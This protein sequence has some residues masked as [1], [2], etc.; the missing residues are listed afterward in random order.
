[1]KTKD[2]ANCAPLGDA[3]RVGDV[4][5]IGMAGRFPHAE[6]LETLRR[7]LAGAVDSVGP[8]SSTRI[9][10]TALP[11][12][13][14]YLLA[15]Y[16]D[17]V[18]KFDHQL[19]A[20]PLGE[21]EAMG[22][23]LRI[24]LEVVYGALENSG[25]GVDF[26][27]GS[28]AG[29]YAAQTSSAYY[30]HADELFSTLITGN[31]PDFFAARIARQF[32]LSGP[33]L[34]VDTAC[35]SG[36]VALHLA[37]QALAHGDVGHAVVC[38][39]HVHVFPFKSDT[40]NLLDV[41]A[42]DGK[43]RAF[44]ARAQGMSA[45]EVVCAL[46]L[47]PLAQAIHD[48][49][50]IH[51][52]VTGSAV[53]NNAARSSSPSAPDSAMQARVMQ[54][55]WRR[56][57]IAPTSLGFIE[58]H[59]SGTQLGD[60]LEVEAFTR[61]FRAYTDKTG[62][63]PIS[64][65]KSNIGHTHAAAGLAGLIKAVLSLKHRVVFPAVH[66][67][68]P[69][70]LIDF[71]RSAVYVNR[72]LAELQ[73][74][75]G[76]P[77]R[78]GVHA[79]G[80]SG[81]N[82]HVVMEEGPTRVM[83]HNNSPPPSLFTLSSRTG[84]GLLSAVRRLRGALRTQQLWGPDVAYTLNLGR[85]HFGRR[86][87]FVCSDIASLDEALARAAE[88][89]TVDD[90]VTPQPQKLIFA[91]SPCAEPSSTL[92]AELERRHPPFFRAVSYCREVWTGP[93][94]SFP[95]A[96]V[97]QYAIHQTLVEYGLAP[98][99]IIGIGPG[100]SL[101]RA[102]SGT[103]TLKTTLQEWDSGTFGEPAHWERK[104]RELMLSAEA[105]SVLV[106]LGPNG[107]VAKCPSSSRAGFNVRIVP[108]PCSGSDPLLALCGTLYTS[109]QALNFAALHVSL[110]GKR[111][112]LPGYQFEKR[113]CW[114]RK[115]AKVNS[116]VTA[117]SDHVFNRS[118]AEPGQT[119]LEK[120]VRAHFGEVVGAE[121]PLNG[122]FF[123]NGG[124]SLAATKVIKQ[125][126]AT[127]GV[128]L[129]FEDLFDFQTPRELAAHLRR[130]LSTE[131]IVAL[132]WKSALGLSAI[133]PDDDFFKLGGHSLLSTQVLHRVRK[134]F[135]VALSFEDFFA[136]PTLSS[137]A[138]RIEQ[139]PASPQGARH[140]GI[141]KAPA[142]ESYELTPSQKHLWVLCQMEG[143][144]VAY[145]LS[146]YDLLEGPLDVSALER[147]VESLVA[148]HDSFRTTF[149]VENEE[150][151]QRIAPPSQGVGWVRSI[152]VSASPA[153][154]A[155]AGRAIS[156]GAERAFDLVNGPLFRVLSL[157]LG[158][159]RNVLC[160]TLHH[161]IADAWSF[162]V[163]L[164]ELTGLYEAYRQ[165]VTPML[166]TPKLQYKDYAV[167]MNHARQREARGSHLAY[168][169][170]K[171]ADP[172]QG[173]ELAPDHP[174]PA[175]KTFNGA[176]VRE[177]I[178]P[179]V[180][181]LIRAV[182]GRQ[183]ATLFMA[184]LALTKVL[185]F[186]YT[187][188]SDLMIGTPMAGR[189][190]PELDDAVGFFVN[191]LPLRTRIEAQHSFAEV[192]A[193]VRVT[194]LEAQEHQMC[195]FDVIVQD[196]RPARDMSRSVY[197]DILIIMQNAGFRARSAS[198]LDGLA[199]REF[200]AEHRIS[201]Y[202]LTFEF[203]E[204]P[205]GLYLELEY[206]VDLYSAQRAASF[207]QHFNALAAALVVDPARPIGAAR[208]MHSSDPHQ[209][210]ISADDIQAPAV[211]SILAL[212][213]AQTQRTPDAIAVVHGERSLSY[214]RLERETTHLA[215]ALREHAVGYETRVGICMERG[216]DLPIAMLG[217]L[218]AGGAFVLMDPSFPSARL[219]AIARASRLTLVLSD[220]ALE[221]APEVP[222]RTLSSSCWRSVV[223]CSTLDRV[224]PGKSLAYTI[225]TSGS[226]G[227][228]K[229]V[230]VT[231]H[232]LGAFLLA[233]SERPGLD[234]GEVLLSV[235]TPTF[236]IFLLEM[237]LPL[238]RGATSV[239]LDRHELLDADG[240]R[241]AIA[242]HRPT[243][244]Q[245][246]PALFTV[247]TE[248]GWNGDGCPRMFC[249]GDV[250]PQAL[251]T[252]LL[253]RGRLWNMYGPTETTVWSLVHRV[254]ADDPGRVP[255]GS[256]IVGTSAYI[257]DVCMEPQARGVPSSLYLGGAG[258]ARGYVDGPDLTAESFVPDPFAREYGARMYRTGDT[259]MLSLNQGS[260]QFLGRRDNQVKVRGFR[261]EL[262]EIERAL[263]AHIAVESTAMTVTG[264]KDQRDRIVAHVVPRAG[265]QVSSAELKAFL[266]LSLPEYMVPSSFV[267][268]E[269][270]PRT[271]N[272]KIDRNNLA[273]R[274]AESPASS[275]SAEQQTD[276]QQSIAF[277]WR[278]LLGATS[279][280]LHDNFFDLGGHSLMVI[281]AH[282]RLQ[283]RLDR[284]F[285]LVLMFQYPTVSV[286]AAAL[287]G[288]ATRHKDLVEG[289]FNRGKM[290]R[291]ALRRQVA[292][293]QRSRTS[294]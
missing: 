219:T 91:C 165:R 45:G 65:I 50:L 203:S 289:A 247:L 40:A 179:R 285:P 272:G 177:R 96:C 75:D 197:F 253:E 181:A 243:C 260:L 22:P 107:F 118:A 101:T 252:T 122:K 57:G 117:S 137:L 28:D 226:T 230:D 286:L 23:N 146:V 274:R 36:L 121:V 129:D 215:Q 86:L 228:P 21:A 53:N 110:P 120:L 145:N 188:Q 268:H 202:D 37:C 11:P 147:A 293:H 241:S 7:N 267:V 244:M 251:A 29:V 59:G 81:V 292:K 176:V 112:E 13:R 46:L 39:S 266:R 250:L 95:M 73:A 160:F 192:L 92:M 245:A 156:C 48:G 12:D 185:L 15:G 32:D 124:S 143:A 206:N 85:H 9:T 52:V 287:E 80:M 141:P 88:G 262:G 142:A 277:V 116:A 97:F 125:I 139:L 158:R 264:P 151:R 106:E 235:T 193:A 103:Q 155:E 144:S 249:G 182:G 3:A 173:L 94:G 175:L 213:H 174:R 54:Q 246:T 2:S 6:D 239:L 201:R 87:A 149:V 104:L 49:D 271:A 164:S 189:P 171:L 237:L 216:L 105:G 82:A 204:M 20:I 148:R 111:V 43:S 38:A 70:P 169:R 240:L 108:F 72:Q 128:R 259:A 33:A 172:Y 223:P 255:I 170:E 184:L 186:R 279:I 123:E 66:F 163:I 224:I 138:K 63:C 254:D 14:E 153:P 168:W 200:K 232:S 281:K 166:A 276:L 256:P 283:T 180:V 77:R 210:V 199:V 205:D 34:M 100:R 198:T 44:S 221:W 69:S 233:M 265:H 227:A 195:P 42:S 211:P 93:G 71:G 67:D 191:L 234:A 222:C 132:F 161:L 25:Y 157:K 154:M 248:A 98:R 41:W 290:Q 61:A 35:S 127:F 196:L 68:E 209:Q 84:D 214:R 113:R 74:L 257:L 162:D 99:T 78:V 79:F 194:V 225:F 217:I 220:D 90:D 130:Q 115:T 284:S 282:V 58:A 278:Q 4:A 56:A 1:M 140:S 17:D 136:H 242:R 30:Q 31:S 126:N 231:H 51:A 19:F 178:E 83:A 270:L 190:L 76:A 269:R 24:A 258:L 102:L 167:W 261:V 16:L 114:L 187:G 89:V 236:D 229:G 135:G 208:F 294:Q 159:E 280:G 8:I 152:D 207:V 26:F 288:S 134:E 109:G 47:K 10:D 133:A 62:I 119:E 183:N 275:A 27:A 18:D 5:I 218:K 60:S 150:P 263:A 64:S 131:S 212:L 273:L 291:E 55:A 238:I